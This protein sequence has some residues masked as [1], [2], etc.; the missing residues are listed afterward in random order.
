MGSTGGNGG[1]G[2]QAYVDNR[3]TNA[4]VGGVYV[5]ASSITTSGDRSYGLIAQSIGGGGGSGGISYS[6]T[7]TA[8][9][10][11][12]LAIGGSG[13]N[14]ASVGTATVSNDGKIT[15]SGSGASAIVAQSIG[16]GGGSGGISGRESAFAIN[17]D[18]V[19]VGGSGGGGGDG[20]TA[21]VN[22]SAALTTHGGNA[23]VILAQSI[24]GGGGN[25]GVS[26]SGTVSM[27]P[28]KSVAIGGKG[29]GGGKGGAVYVTNTGA[30]TA[31]S[32]NGN[33]PGIL[34]QSVGGG[35]GSFGVVDAG[36]TPGTGS[37]DFRLGASG[38]R[39]SDAADVTVTTGAISTS[40]LGSN[41]VTA[42]SI[43]GGGGLL[44]EILNASQT[45][46]SGSL[47]ALDNGN[48]STG[49]AVAVTV[50]GALSTTG[51]FGHGVV[52]QSIGG[53]GGHLV[54]NSSQTSGMI[55]LGAQGKGGGNS[56][57]VSVTVN[58]K[59]AVTTTG[60]GALG[61]VAQ[62]IGGGGGLVDLPRATG[63][64]LGGSSSSSGNGGNVVVNVNGAVA[65]SGDRSVGV[66]A[67]SV[68]GGG[69]AVVT[70]G[71]GTATPQLAGGSGNSGNVTVTVNAPITTS[72]AGS[73]GVVAQS[74][75]GGGGLLINANGV[76]EFAG[77]G[78][79]TA[80]TVSVVN[81]SQ[82]SVSGAGAKG[83]LAGNTAGNA[84]APPMMSARSASVTASGGATAIVLNGLVNKLQNDGTI[85][86]ANSS[87]DTAIDVRGAGGA[88]SILNN[89]VIAG[90][91]VNSGSRIDIL[92]A[93]GARMYLP[94]APD[95][96]GGT[97]TNSGYLQWSDM[98]DRSPALVNHA[99]S[100]VQTSTGILGMRLDFAAA[101]SDLIDLTNSTQFSLG[102][103]IRPV[104]M[105][106][107][108][109][110]P[111]SIQTT[112]LASSAAAGIQG[113][114]SDLGIDSQSAIMS[115]GLNRS[116]NGMTLTSAAN[117]A[118]AGMSPFGSEVGQAIGSYQSAGS[119]AFF[120]AATAQL[121][122]RPDVA[123]L[124]L[125]YRGLAGSAIQSV[126][127]SV[128]LAV[129][130]GIRSY[131]DR[132]N[133]WRVGSATSKSSLEASPSPSAPHQ[134]ASAV[135]QHTVDQASPGGVVA[136]GRGGPWISFFQSSVSSNALTDRVFG[137]SLA[138]EAESA[139]RDVRGG[140]GLTVSQ[141]S[142]TYD[143]APTPSTPGNSTNV[144]LSLYAIGRGESAYLSFVGY[145]GGSNSS[146]ARQ[147]QSLD[148]HTS[149]DVSVTSYVA[150]AR[151]EAGYSFEPFRNAQGHARVTPFVAVQP[152]YIH[153]KGTQDDFS[154]IGLGTG[155]NYPAND[156]T[157]VP[158]FVG[159]EVSGSHTTDGG[160]RISPFA[161]VSWMAETQQKGR[162]G[163]SYG[164]NQGVSLFYSGSPA[165]GN[166]MQYRIGSLFG[167]DGK[168]SGYFTLDY[169]EGDASY[170]YRALGATVGFR[171]AF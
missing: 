133:D 5:L 93:V 88:T 76:S 102:G 19:T 9:A 103:K 47:G 18:G 169:D 147:L 21:T 155:F 44:A 91:L 17:L 105:N 99:G 51:S 124:D 56:M 64:T 59:M 75:A 58:D 78:R 83:I 141:S 6:G 90:R 16:G 10:G 149:T 152:T 171:Y 135:N 89:G 98:G 160:L 104:L 126:P 119:N 68:G 69:G 94:S 130:L 3:N 111:G 77:T 74:V 128:F 24:G 55:T 143:S 20:N 142:Y 80:G 117:F 114:A 97:L 138:I 67:Q 1:G 132:M 12:G 72:G 146:F 63:V 35:G 4:T 150:A 27:A 38:Q 121:V 42:Q 120:Q 73:A 29:G 33:N 162:M 137:G 131:S 154:S 110:H 71:T 101:R 167:G 107:G 113:V 96:G 40:G 163:A 61:I 122:D 30:I 13:G 26:V 144:G 36:S 31:D 15:T 11:I 148:F 39:S 32:S 82:I 123:S 161:R 28:G 7:F 14:A 136:D 49:H 46:I 57:D 48:A 25:G 125:A 153:Q 100:L 43:G 156:N 134:A 108:L 109:I 50:S 60:T 159:L 45:S 81:N 86:A 79:G 115:Y 54:G 116:A 164:A 23:P 70:S 145:L 85:V 106:A 158:V 112:I 118:P 53:G 140:V 22:N 34:A 170:N 166:A 157:A 37:L 151:V 165:L 62:S 84:S 52:A 65:T 66:L 95:L 8:G 2:G 87:T 41:A 127:Q 92:N 129:S 139:G 168:V